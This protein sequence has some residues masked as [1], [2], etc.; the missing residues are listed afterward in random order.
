[1]ALSIG[2]LIYQPGQHLFMAMLTFGA[3]VALRW[4][5]RKVA[6]WRPEQAQAI[7]R[8]MFLARKH[9]ANVIAEWNEVAT[10]KRFEMLLAELTRVKNKLLVLPQRRTNEMKMLLDE[11]AQ[12]QRY[13]YLDKIS[14]DKAR[15]PNITRQEISMLAAFDIDTAAEVLGRSEKMAGLITERAL[16]EIKAWA[17]ACARNFEFDATR[18]AD[19]TDVQQIDL[20]LQE[21]QE[22][23]LREL[24][25]GQAELERL[26]S[27]VSAARKVKE[28]DLAAARRA[29]AEAWPEDSR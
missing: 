18:G 3:A 25:R 9:L 2:S 5:S 10:D 26:A 6:W 29:V 22:K 17:N 21:E 1:M 16:Q 15:L 27:E 24:R 4:K 28:R 14:L 12:S 23:L 11:A 8:T 7:Y 13:K 19:P 20:T